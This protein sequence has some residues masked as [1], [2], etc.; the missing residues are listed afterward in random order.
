VKA[1][2][3][4]GMLENSIIVFMSDNGAPSVNVVGYQ[5]WGSNYPLRG[6]SVHVTSSIE[7]GSY[8][9]DSFRRIKF[10]GKV[11]GKMIITLL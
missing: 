2:H 1:L 6:V 5:N 10:L 9:S 4:K 8:W 7:C 11:N 3:Q